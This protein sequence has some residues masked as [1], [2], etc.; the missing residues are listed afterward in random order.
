MN[1]IF[2]DFDGVLHP[3][4]CDPEKYFCRLP[5]LED[6]LVQS[7]VQIVISS[8]WRFHCSRDDILQRFPSS[9]RRLIVGFT[10]EAHVGAYARYNEI[11]NYA[12]P[13]EAADWLAID[14]SRFEF[15]PHCDRLILCDGKVGISDNEVNLLRSRLSGAK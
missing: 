7:D 8:S 14:D 1:L 10:G 13:N 4:H 9:L 12:D 5:I 15:P 6:V 2:L 3:V 11:K